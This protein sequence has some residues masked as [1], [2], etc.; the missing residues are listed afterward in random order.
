MGLGARVGIQAGADAPVGVGWGLRREEE[1]QEGKATMVTAGLGLGLDLGL[2][3]TGLVCEWG[4]SSCRGVTNVG[5]AHSGQP[6][7]LCA[8]AQGQTA[9]QQDCG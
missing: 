5:A 6:L 2:S 7:V 3:A 4:T 9:V 8:Q 1:L